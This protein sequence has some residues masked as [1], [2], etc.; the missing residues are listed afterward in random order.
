MLLLP[1]IFVIYVLCG[2]KKVN[3][4]EKY[5]VL[6]F[7]K[8][9]TVL[10]PWLRYTWPFFQTIK[11]LNLNDTINEITAELEKYNIPPEIKKKILNEIQEF[12][13]KTG[14]CCTDKSV[15]KD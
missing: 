4:D 9:T 15:R 11:K 5:I 10:E 3:W 14:G 12:K 2:L 8:Y 1:S 7:W 13:N 6:T